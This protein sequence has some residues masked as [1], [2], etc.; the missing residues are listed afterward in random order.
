MRIFRYI[1][2]SF[3]FILYMFLSI[4]DSS[5]VCQMLIAFL[6]FFPGER[7]YLFFIMNPGNGSSIFLIIN[8]VD[9]T[10]FLC[11]ICQVSLPGVNGL[12]CQRVNGA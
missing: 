7:L 4:E 12:N 11:K 10:K 3:A 9:K 6:N 5:S 1:K 2:T 8:S